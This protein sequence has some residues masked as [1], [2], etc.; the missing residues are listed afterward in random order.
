MI[1][2]SLVGGGTSEGCGAVAFPAFTKL[3]HIAPVDARYF[4][5][6]IQSVG[7]GAASLSILYL[8]IPIERRTALYAGGAGVVGVA[9]GADFVAPFIPPVLVRV[10][11]TV[12]VT[13]LAIALL[14]INRNEHAMRNA[15]CPLFGNR[16]KSILVAAGFIGGTV[17]ALVGCGENIVAF[18]GMAL[19]FRISEKVATPT[20]VILMTIVALAG[21]ASLVLA[22]HFPR[23]DRLL[24][25]RGTR[26][27]CWR[28]P[29]GARLFLYAATS[30][31]VSAHRLN[32]AR[33]LQHADPGAD[34]EVRFA[35]LGHGIA[36]VRFH[37]SGHEPSEALSSRAISPRTTRQRLPCLRGGEHLD[38]F[39]L[40]ML[41]AGI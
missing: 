21:F 23:C 30:H 3:L 26:S 5:F 10:S 33:V 39:A 16:E 4:S 25:W 1:F 32:R 2:G 19:L 14:L 11:F 37:Q 40:T 41:Q 9:L 35:D 22:G 28:P 27:C 17:S 36:L 6:A 18:M 24:A 12:L 8:R 15:V 20:A 29:G 34:V 31:R 7:M 38:R 13:S